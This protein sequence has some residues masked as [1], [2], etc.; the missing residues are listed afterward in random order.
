MRWTLAAVLLSAQDGPFRARVTGESASF[1]EDRSDLVKGT[2]W[3]LPGEALRYEDARERLVIRGGR[4]SS[5]RTGERTSQSWDAGGA[6]RFLAVDLWRMGPD[7]LARRFEIVEGPAEA[8]EP[9]ATSTSTLPRLRAG[10]GRWFRAAVEE[11]A[12]VVEGCRRALL[13]PRDPALRERIASVRLSIELPA[14]RILR[15]QL[16]GPAGEE[17]WTLDGIERLERV[18]DRLFDV[19]ADAP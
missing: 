17:S 5:R 11:G 8:P 9:E 3:V 19:A 18:E 10:G 15:V 6:E 16:R 12:P 2:L 7:E 14:G 4:G 1:R 13:V